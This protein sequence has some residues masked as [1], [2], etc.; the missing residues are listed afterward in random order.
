[1]HCLACIAFRSHLVYIN[2]E[3]PFALSALSRI[4]ARDFFSE[5][6]RKQETNTA[7]QSEQHTHC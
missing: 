7:Q 2:M 4:P 1:M 6:I 5:I 3:S